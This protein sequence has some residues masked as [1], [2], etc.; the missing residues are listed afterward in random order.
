MGNLSLALKLSHHYVIECRDKYGSLKWREDI[1]NLVVTVGQ[2]DILNQY[3]A[4][5][6]Y[7]AANFV[8]LT[9]GTPVFAASDTMASHTGWTEYSAYVEATR[10]APTWGSAAGAVIT[11][12][13]VTFTVADPGGTAGGAFL[14][15]DATIL[16]SAGTLIGG[17]A[18]SANRVVAADDIVNVTPTATV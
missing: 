2:N 13:A 15:T 11:A 4:G 9:T 3:Y 12:P 14:T 6:S 1:D 10:P 16:G 18:F 5:S 8:G 17:A 7:T